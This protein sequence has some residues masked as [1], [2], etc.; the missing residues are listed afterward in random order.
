MTN[1]PFGT[2]GE[3]TVWHEFERRAHNRAFMVSYFERRIEEIKRSLP[4]ERLLIY[5]VKQGWEP[6][7]R[8]LKVPVPDTPFPRMNSREETS[9]MI[10]SM[11]AGGSPGGA[12]EGHLAAAAS[13]IFHHNPK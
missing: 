1:T 11:M 7:C 9:R 10:E 2:M 6:L 13:E 5:D 4:G 3:K 8:F 12:N